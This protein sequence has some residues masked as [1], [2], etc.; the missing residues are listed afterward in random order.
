M[1]LALTTTRGAAEKKDFPEVRAIHRRAEDKQDGAGQYGN[2]PPTPRIPAEQRGGHA[3]R[4]QRNQSLSTL[5]GDS[6]RATA[7]LAQR[8]NAASLPGVEQ[9]RQSGQRH[10]HTEQERE[11]FDFHGSVKCKIGAQAS[12]RLGE[13]YYPGD[14]GSLPRL[15]RHNPA[16]ALIS[17]NARTG[18]IDHHPGRASQRTGCTRR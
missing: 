15:E 12:R 3:H 4:S 2:R 8:G 7:A 1:T 9:D 11:L 18:T 14:S 17:T 6:T 13:S 16:E 10:Q 5:V